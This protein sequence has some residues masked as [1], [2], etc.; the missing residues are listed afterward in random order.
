MIEVNSELGEQASL[1][2]GVD[3]GNA[4]SN[5]E[6]LLKAQPLNH[7]V[8]LGFKVHKRVSLRPSEVEPA[9]ALA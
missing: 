9:E 3:A 2:E 1:A 8:K 4:R 7:L 6:S 5:L